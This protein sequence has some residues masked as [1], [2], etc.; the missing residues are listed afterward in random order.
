M[1]RLMK[2]PL[3]I[4]KEVEKAFLEDVYKTSYLIHKTVVGLVH[5]SSLRI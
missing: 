5:G 1:L 2:V 3:K 4:T